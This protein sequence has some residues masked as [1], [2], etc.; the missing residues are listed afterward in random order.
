MERGCV[1]NARS[2]IPIG[3]DLLALMLYLTGL[4]WLVAR[5]Q[6]GAAGNLLL[7]I[8]SY[9]LFCGA[10][11]LLRVSAFQHDPRSKTCSPMMVFWSVFFSLM[12][13]HAMTD[14]SGLLAFLVDTPLDEM[15]AIMEGAWAMAMTL[16][17][18]AGAVVVVALYPLSLLFRTTR[19]WSA[20]SVTEV[21]IQAAALLGINL[22][23]LV[24]MAHWEVAYRA[25]EPYRDLALGGKILIFL[26]V[27]AFFLLFYGMP[28][29]L[30]FQANPSKMAVAV[31][32]LQTGYFVW[33]FLDGSA[34]A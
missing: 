15:D 26:V 33:S 22:M 19:L 20:D 10:V 3:A 5:F 29:M 21:S 17:V 1:V 32:I 25:D 2:W 12:I 18:L 9:S 23:I 4:P 8:V 31:F 6:T 16:G 30:F 27:Y 13:L 34:W 11:Y 7:L 24:T 28:R 14:L